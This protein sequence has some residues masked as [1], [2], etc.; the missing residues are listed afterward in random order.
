MRL[1]YKIK[2]WN[3][4]RKI[5]SNPLI[6]TKD[7]DGT[8][9][10]T[11]GRFT[12]R[13][14]LIKSEPQE[15]KIPRWISVKIKTSP[16]KLSLR[17]F[18]DEVADFWH[19]QKWVFLFRPSTLAVLI[20][21]SLIIYFGAIEF[22]PG[23]GYVIRWLASRAI[24]VSPNAIEYRGSGWIRVAGTRTTI[25]KEYEPLHYDVN[26]FRLIVF[27]DTGSVTRY[28]GDEKRPVI[29]P[30]GADESGEVYFKREG[31]WQKGE[32]KESAVEWEKPQ[33]VGSKEGKIVRGVIVET[34]KDK[35]ELRDK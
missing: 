15:K 14:Q 1:R 30:V 26:I 5:R 8:F 4:K 31:G 9:L 32:I 19:Y 25:E 18:S 11:E 34:T 35:I 23:K 6:G 33:A 12:I 10:Y 3:I 24:G 29:H 21:I 7:A 13:Y 16:H 22:Q 28:W 17:K 2:I 27:N 20:F